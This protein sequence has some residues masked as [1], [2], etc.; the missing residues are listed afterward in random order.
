MRDNNKNTN[1]KSTHIIDGVS[2]SS[3]CR[4][5][6]NNNMVRCYGRFHMFSC[7]ILLTHARSL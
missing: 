6:E 5:M 2:T 1:K 7:M 3:F 4:Y